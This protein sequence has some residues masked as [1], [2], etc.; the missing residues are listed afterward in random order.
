MSE[1][2]FAKIKKYTNF[3]K[4]RKKEENRNIVFPNLLS[5]SAMIFLEYILNS[6]AAS[7]THG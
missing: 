1:I 4:K 6:I 7:T 5:F 3:G 2:N